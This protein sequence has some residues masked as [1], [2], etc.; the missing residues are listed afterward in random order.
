MGKV[1]VQK[2]HRSCSRS[3]NVCLLVSSR[4]GMAETDGHDK[5]ALP[6]TVELKLNCQHFY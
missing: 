4:K 3:N 1:L 5:A 6:E 2:V